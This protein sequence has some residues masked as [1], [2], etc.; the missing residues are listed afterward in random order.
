[1]VLLPVPSIAIEPYIELVLDTKPLVEIPMRLYDAVLD[2][3]D[4]SDAFESAM[5]IGLVLVGG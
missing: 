1:M 3:E 5:R 2:E 4:E